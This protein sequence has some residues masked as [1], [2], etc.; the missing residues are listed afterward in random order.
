ML[1]LMSMTIRI[2]AEDRFGKR[3]LMNDKPIAEYSAD[4]VKEMV[5][6]SVSVSIFL[7][8]ETR[9]DDAKSIISDFFSHFEGDI[10]SKATKY[11][12]VVTQELRPTRDDSKALISALSQ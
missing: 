4:E 3:S 10:V 1:Y 8:D 2:S 7:K 6:S 12:W 11:G 5:D 9:A